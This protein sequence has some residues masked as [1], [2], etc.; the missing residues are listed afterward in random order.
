[1]YG[2]LFESIFECIKLKY[3]DDVLAKVCDLTDTSSVIFSTNQQYSESLFPFIMKCLAEITNQDPN[4]VMEEM[5]C[6]FVYFISKF[7]YDRILKVLGRHMRDFLNG[8][9]NLHE[10]MK[11]SY[12]KLKP[13]SFFVEKESVNGLILHYRSRRRGFLYYVKGQLK[14][15]GKIFYKIDIEIDV[16]HHSVEDDNLTYAI[17]ELRFQNYQYLRALNLKDRSNISLE[18]SRNDLILKTQTFFDLFPFHL[19]FRSDMRV[20]SIGRGLYQ[21]LPNIVGKR[22]NKVFKL[23]RPLIQLNWESVS[24]KF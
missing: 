16:V 14:Q 4:E 2:L 18:F 5:G 10:Y 12:P 8:L 6:Y 21:L 7:G 17:F 13:P 24:Y 20:I 1:M 15:V 3:G 23:D 11:F 9:D 19:A 22:L